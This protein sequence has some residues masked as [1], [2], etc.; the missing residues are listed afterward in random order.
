MSWSIGL[1]SKFSF[2]FWKSED[3]LT[4]YFVFQFFKCLLLFF[5]PF[6]LFI[7]FEF[8]KRFCHMTEILDKLSVE[9]CKSQKAFYS[10]TTL[11]LSV[12]IHTCSFPTTTP[13]IGISSMLKSHFDHLKQRMYFSVILRNWIVLS[14]SSFIFFASI[15]KSSM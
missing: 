1:Y 12:S 5:S 4:C 14:S 11:T 13:R 7:T 2:S 3:W 15:T 10:L 8:V 6:P 9:I